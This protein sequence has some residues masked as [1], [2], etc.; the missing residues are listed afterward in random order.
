MEGSWTEANDGVVAK[1]SLFAETRSHQRSSAALRSHMV[2]RGK[3]VII[4]DKRGK[5]SMVLNENLLLIP[6]PTIHYPLYS[7]IHCAVLP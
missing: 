6:Q 1:Q 7:L 3:G 4:A 2:S 5:S